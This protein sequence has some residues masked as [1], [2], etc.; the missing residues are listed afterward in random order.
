MTIR[1]GEPWGRRVA[2][3]GS[4]RV[5][6][7]DAELAALVGVDGAPVLVVGGDLARSLGAPGGGAVPGAGEP[8]LKVPI[9]LLDVTLDGR[10]LQAVA[11]VVVGELPGR[12]IRRVLGG[13]LPPRGEVMFVANTDH[14]GG[15]DLLPRAHPNDGRFDVLVV[16]PAMPWRARRAANRRAVSGTHLPHPQLSVSR[17]AAADW[18][19]AARRHVAV[20]GVASGQASTVTVRVDADAA[21]ILVAV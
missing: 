3:P 21:T 8:V 1:K 12:L 14:V 5:A 2:R 20:D 16:D 19:L 13:P 7:T 11:H 4:V 10:R 18:S 9:D 15:A 6:A 17:A